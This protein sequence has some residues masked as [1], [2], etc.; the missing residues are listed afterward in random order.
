MQEMDRLEGAYT[1]ATKSHDWRLWMATHC[2]EETPYS[3]V[4]LRES[5]YQDRY[6]MH[7]VLH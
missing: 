5:Q 4:E 6:L 3:T 2:L 7:T 1:W